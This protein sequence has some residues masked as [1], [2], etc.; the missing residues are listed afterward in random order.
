MSEE[1]PKPNPFDFQTATSQYKQSIAPESVKGLAEAVQ[2][3]PEA[4]AQAVL[5][6]AAKAVEEKQ[7]ANNILS[8]I[9]TSIGKGLDIIL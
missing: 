7:N 5:A 3:L 8:M 4:K 2:H 1:Q 6:A 9:I